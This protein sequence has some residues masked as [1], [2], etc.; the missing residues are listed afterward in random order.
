MPRSDFWLIPLPGKCLRKIYYN[1]ELCHHQTTNSKLWELGTF[2]ESLMTIKIKLKSGK[3][4]MYTFAIWTIILNIYI[5]FCQT[6]YLRIFS[7][8]IANIKIKHILFIF[9][10]FMRYLE[11]RWRNKLKTFRNT[12]RDLKREEIYI[13]YICTSIFAETS[14]MNT[15]VV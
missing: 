11:C 9:S 1:Q 12:L 7:R 14:F 4:I 13:I 15:N 2:W 5:N 6:L 8:K 10:A 3:N